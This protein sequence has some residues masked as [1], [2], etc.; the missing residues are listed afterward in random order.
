MCQQLYKSLDIKV[1]MKKYNYKDM[2]NGWFVGN[3]S[4][5]CLS[6]KDCEVAV[7]TYKAGDSEEA[8]YHKI[9]KEITYIL[10]G[11]VIMNDKEYGEGDII[12]IEP[13][14]IVSFYAI[15]DSKNVVVKIPS[16]KGDKYIVE[17]GSNQ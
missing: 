8:H 11:K 2:V 6:T 7:K 9:A 16:V 15:E 3:F 13:G 12:L 4:P 17:D 1:I 10:K 5:T 14:E